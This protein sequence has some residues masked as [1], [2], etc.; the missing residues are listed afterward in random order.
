[1]NLEEKFAFKIAAVRELAR[2]LK[3]MQTEAVLLMR[4]NRRI[5]YENAALRK[6]MAQDRAAAV[7]DWS[8]AFTRLEASRAVMA[9][10]KDQRD[11]YRWWFVWRLVKRLDGERSADLWKRIHAV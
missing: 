3:H 11:K 4:E 8:K 10:E 9:H 6:Q 2:D 5:K 1:M 7:R